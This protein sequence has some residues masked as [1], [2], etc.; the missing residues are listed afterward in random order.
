[1]LLNIITSCIRP[2]NLPNILD[3]IVKAASLVK[4]PI[5]WYLVVDTRSSQYSEKAILDAKLKLLPP[6]GIILKWREFSD[7]YE[8]NW[9]VN[10]ALEEIVEGLVCILDD[11]NI[12]HP[13]YLSAISKVAGEKEIGIL[14][15]QL[16]GP[17]KSGNQQIRKV[18]RHLIQSGYI[19][20]AQ[21]T[22]SRSLIG[23]TRWPSVPLGSKLHALLKGNSNPLGLDFQPDGIFIE[24]IYQQHPT[25][26]IIISEPLCYFN[27]LSGGISSGN[28]SGNI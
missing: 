22:I 14:Y 5:H 2:Q 18:Y 3:S 23:D 27:H 21:F 10:I 28:F 8:K 13:N 11:D 15:D 7:S 12:M 24:K 26:F 19:D 4:I 17:N 6:E 9:P 1:M 25:K 20:A 16:M